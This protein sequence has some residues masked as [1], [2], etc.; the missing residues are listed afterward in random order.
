MQFRQFNKSARICLKCM[1]DN[2]EMHEICGDRKMNDQIRY[3]GNVFKTNYPKKNCLSI[4]AD[5]PHPKCR[6]YFDCAGCAFL[7]IT[8][9]PNLTELPWNAHI[10]TLSDLIDNFSLIF[11]NFPTIPSF[12]LSS[13]MSI[14]CLCVWTAF[15]LNA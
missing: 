8:N 1:V 9:I 15:K 13:R 14:E 10:S 7:H 12:C 4:V 5:H 2:I 6:S 3:M 11:L